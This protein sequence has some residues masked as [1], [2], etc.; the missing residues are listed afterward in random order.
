MTLQRTLAPVF[1]ILLASLSATAQS[2]ARKD[3]PDLKEIR[4]YRLSM[5][6]VD[7]YVRAFKGASA[8][9]V[10]KK[11]FDNNPPGNAPSL[12]AGEKIINACPAA[13]AGIK[14]AGLKPREFLIVTGALIGDVMAVSMKKSGTIKEYPS[15]ISPEN[16]AFIEQNYDKLQTMLAPLMSGGK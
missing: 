4:D 15:S 1:A 16:A 10:A 5:D 8:D 7:R 6:I 14:T 11:C 13:V 3:D 2:R 12:D 9:P